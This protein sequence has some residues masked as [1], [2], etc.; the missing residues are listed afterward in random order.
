MKSTAKAVAWM[1]DLKE[2]LELRINGSSTIDTIT[3]SFDTNGWPILTLSDGG[4]VTAGNPVVLL[5]IKAIDAVSK[6]IFG[7]ALV[8]FCPHELEIAYELDGAEGEPSRKDLAVI[9]AEIFQLGIKVLVKEVAD[10]T[11]VDETSLNS[12]AVAQAIEYSVVWPKKGM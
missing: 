10:A 5:R 9:F 1:R 4:V 2:R 7:N 11:A 12:T 8:A 6:D 3:E